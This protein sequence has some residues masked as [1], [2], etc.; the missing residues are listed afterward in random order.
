MF[1]IQMVT[2]VTK[3]TICI[4]DK[5]LGRPFVYQ[6]KNLVFERSDSNFELFVYWN[7]FTVEYFWVSTLA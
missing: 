2:H 3:K 5:K 1:G 6:T 4:P 7:A